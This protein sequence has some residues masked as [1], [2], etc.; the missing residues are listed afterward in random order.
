[1]PR[2]TPHEAPDDAPRI[3]SRTHGRIA[4]TDAD[5]NAL[6]RGHRSRARSY[7]T[8]PIQTTG[9]KFWPACNDNTLSRHLVDAWGTWSF[10][11]DEPSAC[12]RYAHDQL[13][14]R[15]GPRNRPH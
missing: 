2:G 5:I 9:A 15:P 11:H 10:R 12:P 4:A 8:Q 14:H 6:Q 3:R 7:D 1:M 13:G